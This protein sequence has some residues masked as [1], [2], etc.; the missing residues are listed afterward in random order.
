MMSLQRLALALA[1]ACAVFRTVAQIVASDVIDDAIR[2]AVNKYDAERGE[3]VLSNTYFGTFH[4]FKRILIQFYS[5]SCPHCKEFD[6]SWKEAIRTYNNTAVRF[7]RI[8]A[9]K[10]ENLKFVRDFRITEFP[11][12]FYVEKGYKQMYRGRLEA[13]ELVQYIRGLTTSP[14]PNVLVERFSRSGI[15]YIFSNLVTKFA[16]VQMDDSAAKQQLAVYEEVAESFQGE[17]VF[18]W[19]DACA[20]TSQFQRILGMPDLDPSSGGAQLWLTDVKSKS[21]NGGIVKYPY[22]GNNGNAA[23]VAEFVGKC[24]DGLCAPYFRSAPALAEDRNR[25]VETVHGSTFRH[26]VFG[27][28]K[29]VLVSFCVKTM[30]KCQEAL[31]VLKELARRIRDYPAMFRGSDGSMDRENAGLRIATFDNVQNEADL[32]DV[33]DLVITE[34]PTLVLFRGMAVRGPDGFNGK[35]SAVYEP[36]DRASKLTVDDLVA[37]VDLRVTHRLNPMVKSNFD[38]SE[39]PYLLENDAGEVTVEGELS[40][41]VKERE[42]KQRG[43]VKLTEKERISQRLNTMNR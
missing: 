30:P 9:T 14:N 43:E 7:A 12:V 2:D 25:L 38:P 10:R 42:R 13:S 23:D 20:A 27:D 21:M 4:E 11:T 15:K 39:K 26:A 41:L 5:P 16:F 1:L 37:F 31:K 22:S 18:I 32:S 33:P 28:G 29:D 3:V 17:V 36:R 19:L 8:D 6:K 34:F 40:K 35:Y 24:N